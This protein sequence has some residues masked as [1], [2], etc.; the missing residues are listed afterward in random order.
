MISITFAFL[1]S[2]YRNGDTIGGP[3][4]VLLTPFVQ[5][6]WAAVLNAIAEH[7]RLP[8]SEPIMR[9]ARVSTTWCTS[10]RSSR[11]RK[12][13][14]ELEQKDCTGTILMYSVYRLDGT[15]VTRPEELENNGNYVVAGRN[16]RFLAVSYASVALPFHSAVRPNYAE[17]ASYL[18]FIMILKYEYIQYSS[19]KCSLLP[20]RVTS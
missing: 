7:V 14:S 1:S 19:L 15:R 8:K 10:S 4:Q 9:C 2:V 16:E 18:I 20:T 3:R 5:V 6:H 12:Y 11:T 13:C 17:S